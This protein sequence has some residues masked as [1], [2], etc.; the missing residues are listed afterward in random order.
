VIHHTTFTDENG[1]FEPDPGELSSSVHRIR[2]RCPRSSSRYFGEPPV[3]RQAHGRPA[4]D[5]LRE[6]RH[7]AIAL[8]ETIAGGAA[9]RRTEANITRRPSYNRSLT[10][11]STPPVEI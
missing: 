9:S 10:G 5:R 1:N 4:A 8:V 11:T 7:G 6:A 3:L 2:V